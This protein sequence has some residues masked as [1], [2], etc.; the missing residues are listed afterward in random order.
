M[1]IAQGTSQSTP[2]SR[3]GVVLDTHNSNVKNFEYFDKLRKENPKLYFSA[4]TQTEMM[5]E[6][7]KQG[8]D[9][10]KR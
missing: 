10:Y 5:N 2:A 6:A 7:R 4:T 9:F 3:P 1:G 8:S